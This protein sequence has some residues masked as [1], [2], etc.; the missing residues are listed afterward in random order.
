M[1]LVHRRSRAFRGSTHLA[2]E[3]RPGELPRFSHPLGVDIII[4]AAGDP[5]LIELQHGFGRRGLL[6]LYPEANRN[7][8]KTYWAHRR[9]FGRSGLIIDGLRG[10]CRDKITTYRM[11]HR[12]QPASHALCRWGPEVTA[13]LAG[14]SSP[15]VLAKPPTGSCGEGILAFERSALLADGPPDSLRLPMLLQE[16][17]PSRPLAGPDGAEHLGCIRHILLLSCGGA[18]LE[19][20]HL[21]SYWRVSPVP[22]VDHADRDALTANISRGAFPLPVSAAEGAVIRRFAEEV[23]ADLFGQLVDHAPIARGRSRLFG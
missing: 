11:M 9:R 1:H 3:I 23:T 21:P 20:Y 2:A 12:Y 17:V 16:F 8:R 19:F 22:M 14:L 13:W 15:F 7:Y 10:A 6:E 4:T 5:L 18:E